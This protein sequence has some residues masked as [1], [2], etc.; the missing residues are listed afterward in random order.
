[1]RL[2]QLLPTTVLQRVD[3]IDVH[4]SGTFSRTELADAEQGGKHFAQTWPAA[5][6]AIGY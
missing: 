1:M 2:E 3:A 6:G 4:L 5:S